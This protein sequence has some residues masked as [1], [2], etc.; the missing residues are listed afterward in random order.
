MVLTSAMIKADAAPSN[1]AAKA[2]VGGARDH[3]EATCPQ[4]LGDGLSIVRVVV[5]LVLGGAHLLPRLRLRVVNHGDLGAALALG[6]LAEL[7]G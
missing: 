1:V 3:G 7:S 4:A 2:I 5:A 6:K